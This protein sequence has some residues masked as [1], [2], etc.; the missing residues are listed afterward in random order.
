M[1]TGKEQTMKRELT[2][3]LGKGHQV[4]KEFIATL[5]DEERNADGTIEN[6]TAKDCIAHNAYWRKHH[7]EDVLAVLTGKT[8]T[9]PEDD[10]I[11]QEV[12]SRYKD[13]PWENVDTLVD[14]GLQRMG[15]AI[16]S[17][18]EDDLQRHDFYPWEQG[19]PLWR[20]IVGN[21]YTHPV[22]HLSEWHIKRGYPARA[23]EMYQEMTR[24]LTSLDDSADW[25]G[26][27]RYNNACSF[28]LLG[29]KETAINELR[30]ALKLNPGLTEWSRQDPD[31]E[32]IRG[33]AGYKALYE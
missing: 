9:Q 17:I 18:S 19:R 31:F 27:I 26:T 8:P 20:E 13:Q 23:A 21:I 6:W 4:E 29:D 10:Q 12:Y 24:Q 22:I 16:A 33:E 3:L 28:S 30:E 14:A 15:E 2:E 1:R 7:A 32:P 5:A 25:Q 11:N